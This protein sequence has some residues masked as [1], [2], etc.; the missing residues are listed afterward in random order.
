[1]SAAGRTARETQDGSR[2]VARR[3]PAG[4]IGFNQADAS[5]RTAAS[6]GSRSM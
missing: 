1:V 4:E 3:L 2:R 6:S 5:G